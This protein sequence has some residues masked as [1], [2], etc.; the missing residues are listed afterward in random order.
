[1]NR[2]KFLK[3]LMIVPVV[4]TVIVAAKDDTPDWLR[5]FRRAHAN[6]KFKPPLANP[7]GVPKWLAHDLAYGR[8]FSVVKVIRFR[9][10]DIVCVSP[11]YPQEVYCG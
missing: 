5:K 7:V 1:M 10:K 4:P 2:R 9:G 3:A 11:R 8:S 6:T